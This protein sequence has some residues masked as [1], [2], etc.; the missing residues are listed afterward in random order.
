[1]AKRQKWQ[2][3][4]AD[5]VSIGVGLVILGI[6]TAGTSAAMVYGREALIRQEHYKAA[7][8]ILRGFMEEAQGELQYIP[9]Q[10]RSLN[11]ETSTPQPLDIPMERGGTRVQQVMVTIVKDAVVE[12]D[13]QRNGPRKLNSPPDF[14]TVTMHARWNER[15]LAENGDNNPIGM[16]REITFSTAV[17]VRAEL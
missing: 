13:D 9:Y 7:A 5:M 4:V 2:R 6:V 12:N 15:D 11:G 3:G 1:M 17:L 10:Q 14:Y 16:A 8:Y